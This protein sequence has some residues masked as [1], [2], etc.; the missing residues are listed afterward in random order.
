MTLPTTIWL[1]PGTHI[2][3]GLPVDVPACG[4]RDIVEYPILSG[5]HIID[6]KL[7]IVANPG[8]NVRMPVGPP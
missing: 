3:D 5:R 4:D 8:G 2:I 6:G 7:A 1:T